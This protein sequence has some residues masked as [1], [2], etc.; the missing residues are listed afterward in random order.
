MAGREVLRNRRYVGYLV[1]AGSA[2]GALFAYVATSAFVLQSMNGLSPIAYSVDFAANA[3]GMTVAALVAA[4]LAGRVATR[5]VIFVGQVAALLA[6]VA[7]LVGAIW[8]D[9]PLLLAVVC[10]FV[11]MTA[12]GLI[13][14]NGGALA[15]AEV[16]EHPGTGSALLGFVQWVAAGTI[17]PLAGLG[18]ED[19]AVPMAVIMVL[20][21]AVSMIGL[22]VLARPSRTGA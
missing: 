13:G 5:P 7:M 4:R 16:P 10:F 20:G 6:G 3:G 14:P 12:Q 17:A 9:T 21:A 15:A 2:M 19:T 22:L 18:G 1:V 8:F 11:L